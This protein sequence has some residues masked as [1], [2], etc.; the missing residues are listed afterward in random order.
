MYNDSLE[1][2]PHVPMKVGPA[3]FSGPSL[4]LPLAPTGLGPALEV[5][6]AALQVESTMC[7]QLVD[8]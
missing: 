2:H 1:W 8:W 4:L 7:S 5:D 6:G 3:L